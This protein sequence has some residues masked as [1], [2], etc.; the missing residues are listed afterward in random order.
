MRVKE[1]EKTA[2]YSPLSLQ[3]RRLHG[4]STVVVPIDVVCLGIVSDRLEK[5][6]KELGLPDAQGDPQTSAITGTANILKKVP[7]F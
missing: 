1:D 3:V 4:V 6:L 2:R 5:S 7:S